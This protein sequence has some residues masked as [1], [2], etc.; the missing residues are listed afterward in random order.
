MK[1]SAYAKRVGVT[2][3]TAFQWWKDGHLQGYQMPTGTIIIT[4]EPEATTAQ[5]PASRGRQVV[6]YA[7]VSSGTQR[8]DLERQVHRLLDYCAGRGYQVIRIVREIASGLSDNRPKFLALLKDPSV[9]TMVV[10]HRDRATQFGF[11]Y[12]QAVLEAQHRRIE[13]VNLAEGSR[14]DLAND[15]A[16]VIYSLCARLYGP[17]RAKHQVATILQQI[18]KQA[19]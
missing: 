3:R 2:Y 9:S 10:D 12:L 17:R 16:S 14:D 4:Q 19:E 6:I 15:L 11:G 7:Q 8:E 1:L 13:V 18:E 5:P